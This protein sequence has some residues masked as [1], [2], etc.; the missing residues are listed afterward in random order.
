M[1]II[2][3]VK[4]AKQGTKISRLS[5]GQMYF[6]YEINKETYGYPETYNEGINGWNKELMLRSSWTKADMFPK[7]VVFSADDI[8]ADD[9][10]EYV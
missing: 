1:N 7:P 10:K 3:A 6:I 4:L 2:E 5:W 9:W 8:L